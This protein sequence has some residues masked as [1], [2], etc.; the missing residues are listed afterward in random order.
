MAEGLDSSSAEAE[1]G[2]HMWRLI[3]GTLRRLYA[4][5]AGLYLTP[6]LRSEWQ[7]TPEYINE[8]P[9]EYSFALESLSEICPAEVLDVGP[10]ATAWPHIM[11]TCGWRVT[12]IDEELNYWKGD[13]FNR[14]FYVLRD[15]VTKPKIK[16]RFDFITCIS[17][18]E[19]IP[20]HQSAMKG[21]FRLL[22]PGGHVVVTFPYNE[23]RYVENV[24]ALPGAGYGKD[25]PY[26]CQVFSRKEIDTWLQENGARILRQ[27]YYQI[28]D[29]ELWTF[30]RRIYPPRKVDKDQKHHLTC[31]LMT[32]EA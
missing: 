4:T 6:L 31:I 20:D 21:I 10:G 23:E 2:D 9:V 30:G 32:S 17:V 7:K 19:H 18:L 24:Y 25:A 29:G 28:F 11:A 3:K 12:A 5:G 13:Y 22:K 1:I 8:R 15:D 27:E 26:K 16:Q 14:H